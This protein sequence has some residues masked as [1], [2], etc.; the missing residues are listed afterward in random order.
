[1]LFV[2]HKEIRNLNANRWNLRYFIITV[3]FRGANRLTP[4]N[5]ITY[6]SCVLNYEQP[7]KPTSLG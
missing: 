6:N 7:F 1:M 5:V 3:R 4:Y 2:H